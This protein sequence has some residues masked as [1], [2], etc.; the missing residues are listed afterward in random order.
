MPQISAWFMANRDPET[1]DYPDLP[2]EEAG[3]SRDIIDPPPP[4][5]PAALPAKPGR[6][7]QGTAESAAEGVAGGA[8][9]QSGGAAAG[10][11]PQPP[12]AT[13]APAKQAAKSKTGIP[14]R[15]HIASAVPLMRRG[16]R[17]I[18]CLDAMRVCL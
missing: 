10:G 15:C 13:A 2:P 17:A 8:R 4:P 16:V 11:A 14:I 12:S 3:G 6:S 5:P 1:G 7:R 9:P 18:A